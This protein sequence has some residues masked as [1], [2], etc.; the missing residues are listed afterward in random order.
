MFWISTPL[1]PP[2]PIRW[3]L[4]DKD[5][6]KYFMTGNQFSSI[7]KT[8]NFAWT[9]CGFRCCLTE[10]PTQRRRIKIDWKI[11]SWMVTYS[12]DIERKDASECGTELCPQL[13]PI[14]V[15]AASRLTGPTQASLLIKVSI[16]FNHNI[17]GPLQT[18][19]QLFSAPQN[20]EQRRSRSAGTCKTRSNRLNPF[21]FSAF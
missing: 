19:Y 16:P 18:I 11:V 2:A 17:D 6:K 1:E 21:T 20:N 12:K 8:I 4:N 13:S 15:C 10:P 3:P 5:S 9:C 7:F 14:R